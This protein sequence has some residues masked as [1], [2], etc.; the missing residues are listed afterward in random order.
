MFEGAEA[1]PGSR[2]WERKPRDTRARAH[3]R[4]RGTAASRYNTF[5][6]EGARLSLGVEVEMEGVGGRREAFLSARFSAAVARREGERT[7]WNFP[8]RE[9]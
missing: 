6:F 2:L 8:W 5:L 7:S 4:Q 1:L 9:K 3:V